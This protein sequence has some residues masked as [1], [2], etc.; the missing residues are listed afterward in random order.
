L[1]VGVEH[2][3]DAR[4]ALER[5]GVAGLLVS[6]V[7]AILLV[8][9]HVQAQLVGHAHGL[10]GGAIVDE[11]EIVGHRPI[12]LGDGAPQGLLRVVCGHHHADARAADHDETSRENAAAA[13]LKRPPPSQS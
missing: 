5:L 4:A 2:H 1:V 3:H 11:D 9:Q 12:D 7:A 8:H 6:A 10:V 13:A